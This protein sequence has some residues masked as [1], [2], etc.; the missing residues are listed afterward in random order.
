MGE[1]LQTEDTGFFRG[2]QADRRR[3]HRTMENYYYECIYERLQQAA[4]NADT[5]IVLQK[6][7]AK[8][9]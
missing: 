6:L 1:S 8:I 4:P 9:V 7:K 2:A 5:R 3:D